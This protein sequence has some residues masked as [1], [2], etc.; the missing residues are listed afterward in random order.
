MLMLDLFA[1]L[2]GASAA[3]KARGWEVITVDVDPRFGCTCTAD[4][5]SW[6]YTGRRLDLV[7][8]SP[9]CTEFSRSI[10]PWIKDKK[11]P[12]LDLL[13][14]ARRI[15]G[16]C[17]PTWW[18]IENVRG[19][20]KWFKPHLGPVRQAFGPVFLW[21]DFPRLRRVIVKPFKER[22]SSSRRAERAKVPFALSAALAVACESSVLS[23]GA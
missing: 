8:A 12:S 6:R 15:I 17:D 9:P 18:V 13:F 23:I 20:V 19:A 10:L 14:A 2:G 4:L 7:W 11:E 16:E 1:G 3:M 22:L 5:L 21:G